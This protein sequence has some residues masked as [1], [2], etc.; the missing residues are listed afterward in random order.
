[1]V[2]L[3]QYL[4]VSSFNSN[5]LCLVICFLRIEINNN[6]N[7]L[8]KNI[9]YK[10]LYYDNHIYYIMFIVVNYDLK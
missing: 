6:R 1:M 7:W 8:L 4:L 3:H 10:Y 5:I 2:F 9:N